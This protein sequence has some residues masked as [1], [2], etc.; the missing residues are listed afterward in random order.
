M[1]R[2][3]LDKLELPQTPGVYFWRDKDS[4]IL[5]IGK[6][7]NLRDRT[8]SYFAPDL[9]KTRGA[10]LVDMVFKSDTVTW[11]ETDSVLEAL[12]LEANLIKQYQPYYNR[13]EKDDKSFNCV[14]ITK[15][16]FPRVLLVRQKDIDVQ[17]RTLHILRKKEPIK[18]DVVFG[19]YPHSASLK[20]ALRIIRG[21]F[22]FRDRASSMPDKEVFYQQIDLSP[23]MITIQD[24]K[25]YRKNIGRIKLMLQGKFKALVHELKSDMND[26]AKA[27]A[28]EEANDMKQKLF[29]LEHIKDV[30]L[31]KR[32]L[33]ANN[34]VDSF[35]IEAYDVAHLSGKQMVGVM[36]VIENDTTNK[37][38]Y[39]KFIIREFDRSNDA[40]ALREVLVRRLSHKEWTYPNAIVVD[41]NIIQ[42]NAATKVL[43]DLELNIPIIAVTKD[44]R[45]RAKSISG[46]K[47][48][49]ENHKYAILLANAESHRFALTFHTARRK[50]AML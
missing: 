35:R 16:L 4:K 29:A 34:R 12:I 31:L 48:I 26:A 2:Q 30:S 42:I 27:Q 9:I 25:L 46:D 3:D 20:E 43:K 1:I 24:K 50:K 36:S 17:S 6:A 11:Q 37:S 32:D 19:P 41:G 45:H 18:Y 22:P 10:R 7:T 49:I 47:D 38:D 39:R 21:I 44:D 15:D 28:F 8:R 14:A 13:D 23:R 33:V 40:G 5:Y